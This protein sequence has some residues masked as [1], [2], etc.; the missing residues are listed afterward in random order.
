MPKRRSSKKK[1]G[2]QNKNKQ[3]KSFLWN[4]SLLLDENRGA[5]AIPHNSRISKSD[6]FFS[7][8]FV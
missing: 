7:V 2:G 5:V 1:S 6:I 8:Y 4:E 3:V